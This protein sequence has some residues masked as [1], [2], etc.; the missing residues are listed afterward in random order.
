MPYVEVW[1]DDEG[2]DGRCESASELAIEK[3][4]VSEAITLLR[5]G[6]IAE[7]LAA[8]EDPEY[9]PIFKTPSEMEAQYKRWKEGALSGFVPPTHHRIAN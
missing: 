3:D 4:K 7:A 2:C 1:V 8:L 9:S 6:L 5:S